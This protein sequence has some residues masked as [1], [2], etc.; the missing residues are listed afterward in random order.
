MCVK[1]CITFIALTSGLHQLQISRCRPVSAVVQ[2]QQHSLPPSREHCPTR[3][4]CR[5]LSPD[6]P[7]LCVISDLKT[8]LSPD[9]QLQATIETQKTTYDTLTRSTGPKQLG[10]HHNKR[11]HNHV[12]ILQQLR[13]RNKTAR[14][15]FKKILPSTP[16]RIVPVLVGRAATY[17]RSYFYVVPL[18]ACKTLQSIR[19]KSASFDRFHTSGTMKGSFVPF[20][21]RLL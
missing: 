3:C 13:T 18:S 8:C 2:V 14:I 6:A 15:F 19:C 4:P 1:F 11:N 20:L 5:V 16:F 7:V 21:D 10:E 12:R 17:E 9:Q